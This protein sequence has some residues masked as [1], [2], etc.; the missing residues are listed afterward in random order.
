MFQR[1]FCV[2]HRQGIFDN[3]AETVSPKQQQNESKKRSIFESIGLI[4]YR[5]DP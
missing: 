3:G 4:K 1:Y 5:L 2:S